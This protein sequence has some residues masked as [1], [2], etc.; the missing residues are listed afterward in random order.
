MVKRAYPATAAWEAA[1]THKIFSPISLVAAC[2]AAAADA[3]DLQGRERAKIS[4]TASNALSKT[5]TKVKP[6]NC[7]SRRMSSAAS[8][9]D[10]G[11]RK[12]QSENAQGAEVR[13]SGSFF[14]SWDPWSSR[15]NKRAQIVTVRAS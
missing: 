11:A 8:A 1:W 14:A 3:E 12:A 2:L 4:F 10:E 6:Q 7:H 9:M 13:A 5:S 15:C